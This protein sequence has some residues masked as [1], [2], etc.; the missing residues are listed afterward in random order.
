MLVRA[1]LL[2]LGGVVSWVLVPSGKVT[3]DAI[4]RTD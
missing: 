2:V 3:D 4:S 1:A